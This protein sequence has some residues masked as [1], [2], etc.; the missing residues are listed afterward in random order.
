MYRIIGFDKEYGNFT[1]YNP[2]LPDYDLLSATLELDLNSSGTLK[3]KI[4]R[5]N[6][7]YGYIKMYR[8]RVNV[9][10]N[11]RL[12]FV[13]RAY[14]P[15]I[16]VF[17]DDEIECEGCLAYLNDTYQPLFDFFGEVRDLFS[18]MIETHNRQLP[19]DDYRRFIAEK[20]SD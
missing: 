9:Y 3:L 16:D 17:G 18:T 1:I 6:P 13:G 15:S 8:T 5:T 10:S 12:V 2:M 14:G 20:S 7:S 11:D 19:S 4:P